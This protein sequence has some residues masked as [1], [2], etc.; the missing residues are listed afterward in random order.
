MA[1]VPIERVRA[2]PARKKSISRCRAAARTAPS[3]GACSTDPRGRAARDRGHLRLQSAGAIN[4]VMLADGLT[5]RRAARRRAKR[6]ADSGAR[7]ASRRSAGARARRGRPAALVHCRCRPSPTQS[8]VRCADAVS[9]RPTTSTRSNINPLRDL[10]E[11][12]RS[13]S[14]R[15][16]LLHSSSSSSPPPMSTPA[17]CGVPARNDHGRRGDGLG[18]PADAVSRGRDRRRTLLGRRLYGQ[19]RDLSV[20]SAAT[21]TE[22]VLIVQINPLERSM[23]PTQ[24]RTRS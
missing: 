24:P 19:S 6:L 9:G 20:S 10:I 7:S 18:L 17:G 14:T 4:A 2:G 22:D 23:V 12:L 13:T 16:R 8:L 15:A 11:Q 3:P 1:R 5:R 21:S